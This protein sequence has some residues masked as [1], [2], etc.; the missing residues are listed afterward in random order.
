M[1]Y[2]KDNSDDQG[3]GREQDRECHAN[4][5]QP[6]SSRG[7]WG[8]LPAVAGGPPGSGAAAGGW[9]WPRQRVGR[10]RWPTVVRNRHAS[11]LK[12]ATYHGTHNFDAADMAAY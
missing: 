2:E 5:E 1:P 12:A 6:A 3:G 4:G 11:S 9:V 10:G 8:W 7:W